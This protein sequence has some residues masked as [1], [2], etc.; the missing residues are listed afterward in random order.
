MRVDVV[1]S[2]NLSF[3]YNHS[4]VLSDITF[5]I[6]EGD[7]VAIAGPNGSG[8]TTLI[9]VVLGFYRPSKGGIFLFGERPHLFKDWQK[10]GYLP[11][12]SSTLNPHFPVTVWEV[13]SMGLLS[14]K[15]GGDISRADENEA[16]EKALEYMDI[17]DL[18]KRLLGELSGGQQQRVLIARA[19][20]GEPEL[21]ILDEP[22]T[23]LDPDTRDRF[24]NVLSE[25]NS[26]KTTVII[27]THDVG[28]I[29]KYA[30]KLFYLDKK[31]V[32][33]GSFEAFCV[34]REM[35]DYFG[36]YSQHVICHRHD[37]AKPSFT[38]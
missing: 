12:K 15:K 29:G 25:M 14:R 37:T 6:S 20:V 31:M 24:F 26:K 7:Y 5:R 33:Y 23:A 11:Q 1:S 2:E 36:E 18:K 32:F 30:S 28:T 27:V 19:I 3:Q 38:L 17:K 4:E 35:A 34:S 16:I 13:V 10:I 9:K 22:T 8:K 21:L